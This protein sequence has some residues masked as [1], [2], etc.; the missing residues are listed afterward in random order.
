MKLTA[1]IV[2]EAGKPT[3]RI[4][5]P[6]PYAPMPGMPAMP[7]KSLESLRQMV[8][9]DDVNRANARAWLERYLERA[10]EH[11]AHAHA[12][13]SAAAAFAQCLDGDAEV[14]L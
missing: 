3:F 7:Q 6:P 11:D 10:A 14:R 9:A 8:Q 5:P 2:D 1:L 4:E 13:R 12:L